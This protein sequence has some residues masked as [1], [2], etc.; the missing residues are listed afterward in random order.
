MDRSSAAHGGQ[1]VENLILILSGSASFSVTDLIGN[2]APDATDV[3]ITRT[4]GP[5]RL[6]S[7]NIWMDVAAWVCP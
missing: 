6:A 3:P 1:N 5:N 7:F 4:L 2:Y